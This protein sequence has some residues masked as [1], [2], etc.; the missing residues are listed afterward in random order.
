MLVCSRPAS[1]GPR[2]T[3]AVRAEQPLSFFTVT[4]AGKRGTPWSRG[5]RH[6]CPAPSPFGLRW[7]PIHFSL[8]AAIKARKAVARFASRIRHGCERDGGV[9]EGAGRLVMQKMSFGHHR[10][11]C[12]VPT[13]CQSFLSGEAFLSSTL[14]TFSFICFDPILWLRQVCSMHGPAAARLGAGK[15]FVLQGLHKPTMSLLL[16]FRL[17]R[18]SFWRILLKG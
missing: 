15:M 1:E 10:D 12:V 7:G 11:R 17:H 5:C 18:T 14:F 3:L 9:V 6:F 16:L 4:A 8:P 2:W 13:R